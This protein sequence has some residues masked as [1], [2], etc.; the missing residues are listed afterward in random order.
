MPSFTNFCKK[1]QGLFFY[2]F[3]F[4]TG[5]TVAEQKVVYHFHRGMLRFQKL[6][7]ADTGVVQPKSPF[8]VGNALAGGEQIGRSVYGF[9]D[10]I[11]ILN[12]G[13]PHLSCIDV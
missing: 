10:K 1:R 3:G 2:G 8:V 5:G 4:L 13:I 12:H 6:P 11:G 9:Q 7:D